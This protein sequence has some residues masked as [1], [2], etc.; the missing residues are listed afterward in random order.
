MHKAIQG[1][2]QQRLHQSVGMSNGTIS[3]DE[4]ARKAQIDA[5]NRDYVLQ[6]RLGILDHTAWSWLLCAQNLKVV[7]PAQII[8]LSEALA[9][10]WSL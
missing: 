6:P 10:H 3:A 9:G 2:H 7:L 1:T 8:V 5:V 4:A